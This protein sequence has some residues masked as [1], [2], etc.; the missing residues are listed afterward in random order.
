MGRA[1]AW[2]LIVAFG[3]IGLVVGGVMIFMGLVWWSS[4]GT[5]SDGGAG[6]A[7]M[8]SLFHDG[9][10]YFELTAN[11][12]IEGEPIEIRRTIECE[13]YFQHRFGAGYFKKRWYMANEAMTHRLSDGSGVI[14]VIPKLCEAFAK[15]QPPGAPEWGAFP[16]LPENFIPL[17]L[18]TPDA[19]NPELLEAYYSFDSLARPNSRVRFR[20]ISLRNDPQLR[21]Q[22]SPHEFGLWNNASYEGYVASNRPIPRP[23]YTGYHVVAIASDVWRSVPELDH[24]LEITTPSHFLD[25]S[26]RTSLYAKLHSQK[27]SIGHAIHGDIASRLRLGSAD[28]NNPAENPNIRIYP[29]QESNGSLIALTDLEGLI[30]YRRE[31]RHPTV[32]RPRSVFIDAVQI[33]WPK[34]AI[35]ASFYDAESRTIVEQGAPYLSFHETGTSH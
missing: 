19:E 32:P 1:I 26:L 14:V 33:T 34:G 3:S 31:V 20:S 12:E 24:S 17:I 10:R 16:E 18:W 9:P 30:L 29:T 5:G 4:E 15:P 23:N 28:T 25:P 2:V 27:Y 8:R 22:S 7:L 21:P 35:Q 6:S 11:L 13:P